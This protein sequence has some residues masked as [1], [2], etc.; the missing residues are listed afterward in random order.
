MARRLQQCLASIVWARVTQYQYPHLTSTLFPICSNCVHTRRRISSVIQWENFVHLGIA[1][2]S[3]RHY[4]LTENDRLLFQRGTSLRHRCSF[5]CLLGV[6]IW[7]EQ[8]DI[9][10]VDE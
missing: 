1:M 9:S 2:K 4:A 10:I 5:N 7:T 6:F 8:E 3:S